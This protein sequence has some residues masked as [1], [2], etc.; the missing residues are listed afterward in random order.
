[1]QR[2]IK[3][4]TNLGAK[5]SREQGFKESRKQTNKQSKESKNKGNKDSR[6]YGIEETRNQGMKR[7]SNQGNEYSIIQGFWW[8]R[9]HLKKPS[10]LYLRREAFTTATKMVIVCFLETLHLKLITYNGRT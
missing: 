6:N 7:I 10:L 2:G 4:S 1:M 3:E 8:F 5:E 9:Y